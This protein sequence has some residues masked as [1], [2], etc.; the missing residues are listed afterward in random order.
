MRLKIANDFR[1]EQSK[2]SVKAT[3]ALIAALFVLFVGVL[4]SAIYQARQEAQRSAESRADA[5]SQVVATNTRWIVELAR[6]ALQRIDDTLGDTLHTVERQAVLNIADAVKSLPGS[7]KAFVVDARGNVIYSTDPSMTPAEVAGEQYFTAP[8]A[9]TGWYT[10]SLVVNAAGGEQTFVFSKRLE[11]DDKFAGVAAVSFNVSQ[12]SEI[13]A[14]LGLDKES[15]VS[16]IRDDGKLVARYPLADGPIDLSKY[17]LFT[18]YLP[19]SASGVYPAVSPVDGIARLVGYRKVTGTELVAIASISTTSA[20]RLFWRNTAWILGL[21][22]PTALALAFASLWIVRLIQSG[23]RRQAELASALELNRLLFRDTHHRVKNNLQSVQSLVRMQNIPAEVKS[24]LQGRIAAMTAVHEHMYRLDQYA[25]IDASE[26]LPSIIAPLQKTFGTDHKF[27]TDIEPV[28]V[29][30][31]F[32]TPLALLVNEV[33]TNALKYA[34][35]GRKEG[36][37]R[38]ALHK[39]GGRKAELSIADDGVGFD[40]ESTVPGMGNRLI[41]AMVLQLEG[42]YSYVHGNGTVFTAE[43]NVAQATAGIGLDATRRNS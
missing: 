11:R 35:P 18:D 8:A 25:D 1:Q 13:W 17:I 38:V 26:L 36:T 24:D 3:V 16:I 33:V 10:S 27:I 22:V 21:S 37:I 28:V 14:S 31:D 4:V 7:V 40:P 6:Q 15:T 19:K 2:Y 12:I 23:F 43:I 29:D 5:A 30:R 34:F 20:Y 9:G 41:K 42:T 39:R 32:A